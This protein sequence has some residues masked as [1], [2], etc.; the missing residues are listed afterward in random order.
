ML[1]HLAR[2]WSWLTELDKPGDIPLH[3]RADIY[4]RNPL[5]TTT[6]LNCVCS[7][8]TNYYSITLIPCQQDRYVMA[9]GL[10]AGIQIR[11]WHRRQKARTSYH[12]KARIRHQSTMCKIWTANTIWSQQ[13]NIGCVEPTHSGRVTSTKS[14]SSKVLCNVIDSIKHIQLSPHVDTRVNFNQ[15]HNC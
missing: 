10:L 15:Y 11:L 1:S 6:R 13:K 8:N 2:S 3:H 12:T 4:A 7:T 5:T 9:T 14:Q